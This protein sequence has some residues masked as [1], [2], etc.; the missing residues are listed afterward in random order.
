MMES[1]PD[2]P[3]GFLFDPNRCTGCSACVLACSTENELDWGTSWRQVV[4]FNDTRKSGVPSFHLSL[5][6]NHCDEAPCVEQCPAV[7]IRRDASTGAVLIHEDHCIGCGYCGWVC[8]YDAPLFDEVRSVMT[9]C[10]LCN[11]RLVEGLAPA[12]VESCPTDAL[13]FGA[14]RGEQALPGFPDTPALPRIRFAALRRDAKPPE[15]TWELPREVLSAYGAT[16]AGPDSRRLSL[17]AEWPLWLFTTGAAGL[18]GWVLAGVVGGVRIPVD[19]FATL[20]LATMVVSTLH[21]GQKLRVWRAILNLRRSRLSR[22]VVTYGAFVGFAVAWLAVSPESRLVG[23]VAAALGLVA[24]FTMDRV[25]DPVRPSGEGVA[26]SADVL[27]TGPLF[28]AAL[29]RSPVAFG[30]M[31]VLKAFLFARRSRRKKERSLWEVSLSVLRVGVGLALPLLLWMLWPQPWGGAGLLMVAIA[32]LGDRAAFYR[33]LEAST[34]R[35]VAEREAAA[36]VADDRIGPP[37]RKGV[38]S[39]R[40]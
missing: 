14:Q 9:K 37:R 39:I 12:C 11:H 7:A 3:R 1:V 30:A 34:P 28:A 17:R 38:L 22:E 16:R 20:S 15:S 6:C 23:S 13:G 36:W 25:Y 4:P 8:P 10:T 29:L 40:G 2:E 18:V 35:S 21:L 24:L 33:G 32:E 31:A 5:A 26:H 27:L 19:L